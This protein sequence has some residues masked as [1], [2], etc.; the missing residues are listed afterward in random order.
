MITVTLIA[1]VLFGLAV[2]VYEHSDEPHPEHGELEVKEV[3]KSGAASG[4]SFGQTVE[5][6]SMSVSI[7]IVAPN[8]PGSPRN[9]RGRSGGPVS[10]YL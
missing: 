3:Q 5:V 10:F 8:A 6:P 1:F 9:E 4:I 2:A 7:G